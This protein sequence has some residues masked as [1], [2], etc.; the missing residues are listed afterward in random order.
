MLI[1]LQMDVFV[2]LKLDKHKKL[3]ISKHSIFINRAGKLSV[4]QKGSLK[5]AHRQT[6]P[7]AMVF[8][9]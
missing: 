1:Y 8:N 9:E 6:K 5:P 2:H 4:M 3:E 7:W